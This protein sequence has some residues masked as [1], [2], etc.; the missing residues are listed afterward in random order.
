MIP[1]RVLHSPSNLAR[2][3][4]TKAKRPL[5][6][7]LFLLYLARALIVGPYAKSSKLSFTTNLSY[8]RDTILPGLGYAPGSLQGSFSP[9]PFLQ[10]SSPPTLTGL[11]TVVFFYCIKPAPCWA[12]MGKR[13]RAYYIEA[14]LTKDIEMY[15]YLIGKYFFI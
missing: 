12:Y 5:A 4:S 10:E 9:P 8:A 3:Q 7:G 2:K 1:P 15:A 6:F 14:R 11:R 13:Q